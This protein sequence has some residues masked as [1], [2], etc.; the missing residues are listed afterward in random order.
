MRTEAKD[1]TEALWPL[2]AGKFSS[3]FP[4]GKLFGEW[5]ALGI[6]NYGTFVSAFH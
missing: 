4:K 5:A 6:T 3:C 1:M 2:A